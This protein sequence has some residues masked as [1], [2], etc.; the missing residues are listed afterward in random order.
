MVQESNGSGN[1]P[2]LGVL[3]T[4]QSSYAGLVQGSDT[5]TAARFPP[6]CTRD[7]LYSNSGAELHDERRVK[8]AWWSRVVAVT[9]AV[10]RRGTCHVHFRVGSAT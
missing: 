5:C 3:C 6:S 9:V 8:A 4:A 7:E 2:R 1:N 10:A